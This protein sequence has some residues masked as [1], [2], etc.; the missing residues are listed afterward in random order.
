[1]LFNS[2]K[3]IFQVSVEHNSVCFIFMFNL[4]T[5]FGQL[6]IIRPSLQKLQ[7]GA[8]SAGSIYVIWDSI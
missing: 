8:C 7:Q 4:T 2:V 6:T 1:M 3:N 5:C